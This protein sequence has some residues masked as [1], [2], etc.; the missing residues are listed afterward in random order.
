MRAQPSFSLVVL[1]L[2]SAVNVLQS[3]SAWW[4]AVKHL[5]HVD[6]GEANDAPRDSPGLYGC[7]SVE[8]GPLTSLPAQHCG[9]GSPA[10]G[11]T[12]GGHQCGNDLSPG[13]NH[14]CQT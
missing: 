8:Q 4:Q 11:E 5:E 3:G 13:H 1:S 9:N 6:Q 2:R 10:E 12:C 14:A 7:T